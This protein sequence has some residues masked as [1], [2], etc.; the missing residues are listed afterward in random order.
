MKKKRTHLTKEFAMKGSIKLMEKNY[1]I[2]IVI[3]RFRIHDS[4][5]GVQNW[6]TLHCYRVNRDVV[7][8]RRT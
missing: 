4:K 1:Y 7:S 6:V 8:N 5:R 3:N 2:F